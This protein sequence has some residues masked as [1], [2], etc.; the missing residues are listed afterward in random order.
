MS[1]K[2]RP[3]SLVFRN[4]ITTKVT[5]D[6]A[7]QVPLGLKRRNKFIANQKQPLPFWIEDKDLYQ[8]TAQIDQ[9]IIPNEVSFLI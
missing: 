2:L 8:F 1:F 3:E 7:K 6:G 5:V 4:Q 9:V